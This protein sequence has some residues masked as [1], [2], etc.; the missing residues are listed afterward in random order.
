[1]PNRFVLLLLMVAMVVQNLH[2]QQ[3]VAIPQDKSVTYVGF[4]LAKPLGFSATATHIRANGWGGSLS[5]QLVNPEAKNLPSD[6]KKNP[7]PDDTYGDYSGWTN[8]PVIDNVYFLALRAVKEF[9]TSSPF[10]RYG[11]EAG[12]SYVRAY[13][14]DNFTPQASLPNY[15]YE[16]TEY[17]TAGLSLRAKAVFPLLPFAGL[18]VAVTSNLNIRRSYVGVEAVLNLGKVR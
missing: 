18:E 15:G 8:A 12:P 1:M 13:I 9:K 14:A 16:R 4:G 10:M 7:N 3:E 11:I 17:I 2:A 5:I 6:Y